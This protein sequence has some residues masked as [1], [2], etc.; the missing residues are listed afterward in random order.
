MR[1]SHGFLVAHF[2]AMQFQEAADWFWKADQLAPGLPHNLVGLAASR[3][4]NGDHEGAHDTV[5]RLLDSEPDFRVGDMI[6]LPFRDATVWARLL[7][8]L[9]AAGAPD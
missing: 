4:F 6:R 9:R 8:G 3:W 7:D 5:T 2:G 1:R